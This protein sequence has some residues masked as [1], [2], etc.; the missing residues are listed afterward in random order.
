METAAAEDEQEAAA[1]LGELDALPPHS[2][3]QTS[4]G[5]SSLGGTSGDSSSSDGS[6]MLGAANG[7]SRSGA[8]SAAAA[9]VGQPRPRRPTWRI[10]QG[11]STE[12]MALDVARRCRLPPAVLARA[13]QLYARLE[14]MAAR[15]LEPSSAAHP[16]A[17]NGAAVVTAEA[18]QQEQQQEQQPL[19]SA[20]EGAAPVQVAARRGRAARTAASS[21]ASAEA[22]SEASQWT[23]EAAAAALQEVARGALAQGPS[24]EVSAAAQQQ[25]QVGRVQREALLH[26]QVLALGQLV[27]PVPVHRVVRHA[28]NLA[29]ALPP[30]VG[31][32]SAA[33]PR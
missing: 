20:A 31:H 12:S 8:A 29:G 26:M 18:G 19:G 9:A 10:V 1:A 15:Q 7:V 32:R 3:S 25:L 17:A 33:T 5:L 21:S 16:A 23:L 14:P 24:E 22:A 27:T 2:S 6:G 11:V 28:S 13:G 30:G 4:G